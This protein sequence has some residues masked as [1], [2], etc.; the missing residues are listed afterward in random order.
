MLAIEIR[1]NYQ[2]EKTVQKKT[3]KKNIT[4]FFGSDL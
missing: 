1:L 4:V 2:L 3:N